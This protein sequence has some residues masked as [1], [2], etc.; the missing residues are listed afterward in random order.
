MRAVIMLA[1]GIDMQTSTRRFQLFSER[2]G[3]SGSGSGGQL[4]RGS[5]RRPLNTMLRSW[6]RFIRAWGPHYIGTCWQQRSTW[7][8]WL[9][10]RTRARLRSRAALRLCSSFWKLVVSRS[11]SSVSSLVSCGTSIE[12]RC[13]SALAAR[14]RCDGSLLNADGRRP[15]WSQPTVRATSATGHFVSGFW[16]S[17]RSP[18][19]SRL[20][21]S[22]SAGR[23]MIWSRFAPLSSISSRMA[24][25]E[26]AGST[27]AQAVLVLKTLD[28][29]NTDHGVGRVTQ[30]RTTTTYQAT[31]ALLTTT[32]AWQVVTRRLSGKLLCR[33]RWMRRRTTRTTQ[34]HGML[35]RT[36]RRWRMRRS[37]TVSTTTMADLTWRVATTTSTWH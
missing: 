4:N 20:T 23:S 17:A 21:S 26:A 29:D 8:R 22:A 5:C 31:T 9:R 19:P 14:S 2:R 11:R 27:Q 18:R 25:A 36:R 7:R 6:L 35:A 12:E 28:N 13:D 33:S 37:K 10:R 3:R 15:R 24:R 32:T 34:A 1:S 30:R 16:S